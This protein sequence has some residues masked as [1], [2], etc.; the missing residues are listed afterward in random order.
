MKRKISFLAIW[1]ALVPAL[2]MAQSNPAADW[3]GY[4]MMA[5]GKDLAGLN[6]IS[7]NLGKTVVE[8]LQP[9]AKVKRESIDAVIDDN[10]FV[11]KPTGFLRAYGS[12]FDEN[13]YFVPG[14]DRETIVFWV[15][16]TVRSRR[17][18]LN[19]EHPRNL[20]PSWNGHSVGHWEGDTLVIDTIGFNDQTWLDGGGAPHTEDT[21]LTERM[22]RV[23][24]NGNTYIEIAVQVDDPRTLTSPF[25]FSRYFKKQNFEMDDYV[26]ND[27]VDFYKQWR[28]EAI[29]ARRKAAAKAGDSQ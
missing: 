3:T 1:M 13:F 17:I 27:A 20:K 10:G 9:W 11:C 26:C 21:H 2:A 28:A 23:E 19:Q 15:Y 7:P 4:Y 8:H 29:E 18:Y 16:D 5:R 12:P 14:R 24:K 6:V 22:R 25:T